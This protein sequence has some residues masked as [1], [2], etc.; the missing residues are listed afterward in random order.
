MAFSQWKEKDGVDLS[1]V[2]LFPFFLLGRTSVF[3]VSFAVHV[4]SPI[5]SQQQQQQTKKKKEKKKVFCDIF[6]SPFFALT[7]RLGR[8]ILSVTQRVT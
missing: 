3:V 1:H 2:L 6:P 4:A 8:R 7:S 5:D